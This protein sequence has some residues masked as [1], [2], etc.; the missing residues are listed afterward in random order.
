MRNARD[1]QGKKS[2]NVKKVNQNMYGISSIECSPG[3]L[4]LGRFTLQLC[5][6]TAKKEKVCC[7]CKVVFY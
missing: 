3:S 6:T 4:I 5:K 2:G 1:H 7:T